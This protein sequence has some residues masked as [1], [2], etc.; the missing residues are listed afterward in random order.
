MKEFFLS[1]DINLQIYWYIA[2]I[3]SLIFIVQTIM[4]FIGGD[5]DVGVEA[6]FDGDLDGGDFPFQLFSLRNL[7]NFF[8]GIGWTG[9][10]LSGH[11]ESQ[12]LVGFIA[13]LVGVIFIGVFFIVARVMMRLAEDNSFRIEDAV[14]K[15]GDVYLTIP[16]G[17]EGRGRIQISVNGS[18]H[19]LDAITS[20]KES[21]K[22]GVLVKVIGVDS[23]ILIVQS[24]N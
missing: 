18:V 7:V 23:N 10:V 17:K 16:A 1:M 22:V 12:V 4:T 20:E 9:V 14:G 19:E 6:D 3:A 11:I 13:F 21:L 15:T 5:S 24:I 8:L 2:I